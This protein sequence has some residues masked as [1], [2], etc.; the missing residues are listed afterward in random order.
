VY[1]ILGPTEGNP[2]PKE[3]QPVEAVVPPRR[4]CGREE[5]NLQGPKPAGT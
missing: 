5:S 2:P 4:R 3:R 1:A